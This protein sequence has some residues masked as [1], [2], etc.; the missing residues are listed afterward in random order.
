MIPVVSSGARPV[1]G[2]GEVTA[3][4]DGRAR[5]DF[6][7]LL[8]DIAGGG[9]P[10]TAA[11]AEPEEGA[12]GDMLRRL[13]HSR[14]SVCAGLLAERCGEHRL[15]RGP[16]SPAG[17]SPAARE[18]AAAAAGPAGHLWRAEEEGQG[19]GDMSA[20]DDG[21]ADPAAGE[22]PPDDLQRAAEAA[23]M[24]LAEGGR[25]RGTPAPLPD[26]AE[27]A[28]PAEA[29][30]IPVADTAEAPE[31]E[32]PLMP[33]R[34]TVVTRETHFAPVGSDTGAFAAALPSP[35]P[36]AGSPGRAP[37]EG[38]PGRPADLHAVRR[39]IDAE[40]TQRAL[41]G[42]APLSGAAGPVGAALPPLAAQP[43]SFVVDLAAATPAAQ[44]G[45]AIARSGAAVPAAAEFGAVG[46]PVRIL[47]IQLHPVELG[48]V[49]VRLR[50]GRDGLEVRVR[51]VRPET[52]RLLEDDR[53]GLL[54]QLGGDGFGAVDLVIAG[55]GPAATL[56]GH[57]AVAWRVRRPE[58]V[59][60]RNFDVAGLAGTPDEGGQDDPAPHDHRRSRF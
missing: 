59:Q 17:L 35:P 12:T 43:R 38:V 54:A 31:A 22:P 6:D 56:T 50:S 26:T 34:A 5:R 1:P 28:D 19:A 15:D 29:D 53:E 49:T 7:R 21:E 39:R 42:M 36:R 41:D 11:A 55:A 58:P 48:M 2:N 3:E 20:A 24:A 52:A 44:L 45:E 57:D 27:P 25:P 9:G 32:E 4:P 37:P 40:A 60:G 10:D 30:D 14:A 16:S 23:A 8:D 51:A 18:A 47:E 46:G 13:S 33:L